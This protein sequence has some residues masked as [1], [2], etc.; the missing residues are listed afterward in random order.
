M[1][2]IIFLAALFSATLVNAQTPSWQVIGGSLKLIIGGDTIPIDNSAAKYTTALLK[3]IRGNVGVSTNSHD[4]VLVYDELTKSI[5]KKLISAGGGGTG[6]LTNITATNNTGQTWT[7]TNPTTTPNLSLALTSSAVGLTNVPNVDA[8]IRANHTGTQLSSTI[9][10]FITNARTSVSLTTTGSGAA[11]YNNSTGVFNI[12]TPPSG[13]T[14][15]GAIGASPNGNGGTISGNTLTLQP[16]DATNGGVLTS[17]VQN[18]PGTKY[19]AN[20][21]YIN[22]SRLGTGPNAFLTNNIFGFQALNANTTGQYLS[23][24][25]TQSLFNNTSGVAN[26]G[27]GY[28]TLFSNTT[29]GNNLANGYQALYS[30]TTGSDNTAVGLQALY[31]NTTGGSNLGLGSNALRFSTASQ[32]VGLGVFSLYQTTSGGDN[33]ANGFASGYN[34]TTGTGNFF[35]GSNS[36]GGITTG[37]GN[38]IVG[39]NTTGLPAALTNTLL[40]AAGGTT[41]IYSDVSGNTGLGTSSPTAKLDVAGTGKFSDNVKIGGGTNASAL[42]EVVS[43]TKGSIPAPLNDERFVATNV[44]NPTKGLHVIDSVS[45]ILM[46]YNG[47]DWQKYDAFQFNRNSICFYN[48]FQGFASQSILG[49]QHLDI[50]NG[51]AFEDFTLNVSSINQDGWTF[52]VFNEEATYTATF[53]GQTVY[54]LNGS[55]V[56]TTIPVGAHWV[57]R[58]MNGK[59]RKIN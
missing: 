40:L 53:T 15:M 12:P 3:N 28:Q 20:D 56:I 7:I 5:R 47:T 22:S 38:T 24:I 19:L 32:N 27:N 9:S 48:I 4:S 36:G 18:I 26:S 29:G 43:N 42:L 37:S 14:T 41:R 52:S 17:G 33:T 45:G 57:F 16:A 54:Q 30:N 1:K 35:G 2:K 44:L 11:T 21:L 8:T 34:L 13:V 46:R 25:G 49:G 39:A 23:A 58:R 31:A 6:T 55:T 51:S 59:L 10:D 50:A